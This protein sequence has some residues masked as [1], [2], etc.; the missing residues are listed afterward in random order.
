[1]DKVREAQ[2]KQSIAKNN[3]AI[4]EDITENPLYHSISV[5]WDYLVMTCS[6]LP[7]IKFMLTEKMQEHMR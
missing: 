7:T 2:M 6:H 3:E 1:M 4:G 5:Y